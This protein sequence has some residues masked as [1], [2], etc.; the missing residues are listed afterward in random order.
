[1]KV[2]IDHFPIAVCLHRFA[3]AHNI[4]KSEGKTLQISPFF[5]SKTQQN[6]WIQATIS[7]ILYNFK[8]FF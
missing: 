2:F 5:Y 1:M 7:Q 8:Q 4:T 6:E 3:H